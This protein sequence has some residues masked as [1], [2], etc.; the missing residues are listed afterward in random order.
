MIPDTLIETIKNTHHL[1]V[2][3]GA[4]VSAKSG[5]ATFQNASEFGVRL[6]WQGQIGDTL[7]SFFT[8]PVRTDNGYLLVSGTY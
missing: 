7:M 1:V 3:T 6:K 2:L 4:G 5:I 8:L